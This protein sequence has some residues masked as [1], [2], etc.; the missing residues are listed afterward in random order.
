M[1]GCATVSFQEENDFFGI[2]KNKDM[3]YSQGLN[4]KY[5]ENADDA[6]AILK[7]AASFIPSLSVDNG[8]TPNKYTFEAGQHMYTP[9][10]IRATE[11][12]PGEFPYTGL[13]YAKA[14]KEEISLDERK[15]SNLM[16]G[17]TGENSF[18][19]QTQRWFHGIL[20]QQLPNGWSNQTDNEIVFMH[21]SGFESRD[22]LIKYDCNKIEQTS[23]YNLNLGT[24]Q[25]SAEIFVTHYFGQGY[26]LFSA[27]EQEWAWRFY[28]RPYARFVA[29]DMTMDGNT[30]H[31][32]KV[33]VDK[34][35]FVFGNR[36]G[37]VLE[38]SGY[39][40]DLGVT[41]QSQLYEEQQRF[42]QTWGGFSI[43]KMF[44]LY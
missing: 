4:L 6:P 43:S 29:R 25:T 40:L 20:G 42:W 8:L 19:G 22:L 10:T 18:A 7:G 15:W 31:N 30:F 35:P 33:T 39:A 26:E 12:V 41:T 36:F 11:P 44:D 24:W 2:S 21:Q 34:K 28:N 38:H 3:M 13:L 9:D 1:S 27:S 5:V 16:L 14:G 17:T 37:V 32:S 23:G